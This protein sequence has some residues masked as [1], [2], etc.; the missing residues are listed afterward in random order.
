MRT[1]EQI[2]TAVALLALGGCAATNRVSGTVSGNAWEGVVK[3]AEYCAHCGGG[4][5]VRVIFQREN[6]LAAIVLEFEGCVNGAT[7]RFGEAGSASLVWLEHPNG[8]RIEAISGEVRVKECT[9]SAVD[10]SFDAQLQG[11]GDVR[12]SIATP[13]ERDEGYD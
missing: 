10:A 9:S 7:A 12:G 6:E 1:C 4:E 13:L 3:R 8:R 11:G 5:L 2:S